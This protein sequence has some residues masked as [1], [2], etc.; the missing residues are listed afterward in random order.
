ME[1][2]RAVGVGNKELHMEK[3]RRKK[4]DLMGQAQIEAHEEEV[5]LKFGQVSQAQ[6]SL[7]HSLVKK[8][9]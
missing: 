8:E 6:I 9:R 7:S 5:N 4:L 3:E 1:K 2:E